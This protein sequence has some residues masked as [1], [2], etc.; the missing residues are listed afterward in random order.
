MLFDLEEDPKEERN[1]SS[2]PEYAGIKEELRVLLEQVWDEEKIYQE[3]LLA[4]KDMAI[5]R[6]WAK[7]Q[8]AKLFYDEWQQT[9][10]ERNENYLITDKGIVSD[11]GE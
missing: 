11:E 9:G 7:Q 8:G 3:R 2:L 6:E 1:L 4:E 10:R 5:R